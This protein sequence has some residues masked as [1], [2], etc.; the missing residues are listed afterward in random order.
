MAFLYDI[1]DYFVE[2][3]AYLNLKY[4]Y[5]QAHE[6]QTYKRLQISNIAKEW[7]CKEGI[8]KEILKLNSYIKI[9]KYNKYI[10]HKSYPS[11]RAIYPLN[12]QIYSGG[13]YFNID[14]LS[15][16]IFKQ[17]VYQNNSKVYYNEMDIIISL[18][19]Y[20]K[21]PEYYDKIKKS[22][23]LLEV[24]HLIYNIIL[25][26]KVMGVFYELSEIEE[27]KVILRKSTNILK[28]DLKKSEEM[29]ILDKLFLNR[30]SGPQRPSLFLKSSFIN[31]SFS[32][33]ECVY[34]K[35][36]LL[37]IENEIITI[38]LTRSGDSFFYNTVKFHYTEINSLNYTVNFKYVN[39]L[40]I[41]LFNKKFLNADLSSQIINIGS[42]CQEKILMG[43]AEGYNSRPLKSFN[44]I[45]TEKFV[46][47]LG[48]IEYIPHYFLVNFQK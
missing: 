10:L 23:L 11:P 2:M 9:N 33:E 21:Y 34:V 8:I 7:Y 48:F 14:D 29:K 6:F 18:K 4:Y 1:K 47:G 39:E 40:Y 32:K 25:K 5:S 13:Y 26:T 16:E 28:E 37:G 41:F 35:N 3:E 24:G 12:V 46:K 42:I 19:D 36:S 45:E 31:N 22:L 15:G 30:T 43:T 20:N 17:I 38:K 27:D 44:M